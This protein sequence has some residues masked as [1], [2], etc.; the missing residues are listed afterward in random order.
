MCIRDRC[1]V[2]QGGCDRCYDERYYER[3]RVIEWFKL[4]RGYTELVEML[5]IERIDDD[6]EYLPCDELI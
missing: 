4:K 2:V 6:I 1:E 3:V 5:D